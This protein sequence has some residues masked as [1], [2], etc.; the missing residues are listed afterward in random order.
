MT[1]RNREHQEDEAGTLSLWPEAGRIVGL[2]K[3]GTYAAAH[4]GEIPTIRF[5]RK[6]RVPRIALARLLSGAGHEA[7]LPKQEA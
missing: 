3:N 6:Y 2:S 5:G 7:Q 1:K 4:R